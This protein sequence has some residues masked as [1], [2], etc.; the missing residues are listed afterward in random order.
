MKHR[1]RFNRRIT[2]SSIGTPGVGKGRGRPY[3][4]VVGLLGALLPSLGGCG[5]FQPPLPTVENVDLQRYAGKWYEIARYPNTFER[6]CVG[7]TADYGLRDDGRVSVLNTCLEGALDGPA[8][9]I[10]GS[11]RTVDPSNAKLKVRFFWFFEGDYWVIDLDEDYTLAVVGEPSR[12]FLWILS[13]TPQ[14]SEELYQ[15]TLA[16]LEP[17]GYD[18]E[19]VERVLQESE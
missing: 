15:A 5:I 3:R 17:L 6:G 14:I 11:A 10:E 12:N 8:R 18:P 7:V 2:E 13:R 16:K 4:R 9:T 1:I 19:R